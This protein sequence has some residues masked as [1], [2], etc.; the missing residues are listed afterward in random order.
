MAVGVSALAKHAMPC[1]HMLAEMLYAYGAGI[2]EDRRGW[3]IPTSRG[4]KATVLSDQSMVQS[5]AWPMIRQRRGSMRRSATTA[6]GQPGS[7]RSC[8]R[9]RAGARAGDGG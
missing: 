8:Q 7:P 1:H 6:C 5:D 3:L 4:S 2:A 9:R